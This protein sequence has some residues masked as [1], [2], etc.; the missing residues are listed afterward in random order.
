M[1]VILLCEYWI[2]YRLGSTQVKEIFISA[3]VLHYTYKSIIDGWYLRLIIMSIINHLRNVLMLT[4]SRCPCK[5]LA[6]ELL[7]LSIS[8]CLMLHSLCCSYLLTI[9]VFSPSS[10]DFL[11]WWPI[12][13][14]RFIL[15]SF[16]YRIEILCHDINVHIPHHISPKIP[17]YN[18][19]AA[20][21]SIQENWGKVK[22]IMSI[23]YFMLLHEKNEG[24]HFSST[25]SSLNIKKSNENVK[26]V[27]ALPPKHTFRHK[28]K[29]KIW[30]FCLFQ[31]CRFVCV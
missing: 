7:N 9:L 21:K 14:N 22:S 12:L 18:L 17:S 23:S 26:T 6:C 30:K 2:I 16:L 29:L 25:F 20:H 15:T 3:C 1:S 8:L 10:H 4:I 31:S 11:T 24:S 19:R 28:S 5:S 27:F 13:T